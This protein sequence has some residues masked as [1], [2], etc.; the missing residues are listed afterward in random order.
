MVGYIGSKQIVRDCK[1]T[2]KVSAIREKKRSQIEATAK[3]C[4][5]GEH[6]ENARNDDRSLSA[7]VITISLFE[8]KLFDDTN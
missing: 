4:R 5:A 1:R 3:A 6:G 2:T 8:R 7:N